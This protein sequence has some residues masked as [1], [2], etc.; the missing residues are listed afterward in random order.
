[1]AR[2]RILSK[3]GISF[4][5]TLFLVPSLAL[6]ILVY[7]WEDA[8]DLNSGITG[9]IMFADGVTFGDSI[10][11]LSDNL[12]EFSFNNSVLSDWSM[13]DF[14]YGNFLIPE[15]NGID[16]DTV[17]FAINDTNGKKAAKKSAGGS[18]TFERGDAYLDFTISGKA[19]KKAATKDGDT[20]LELFPLW[21]WFSDGPIPC[22]TG[23][24]CKKSATGYS[25]EGYWVLRS[26]TVSV[27]EPTTFLLLLT[28]L[29]VMVS[30][31][32]RVRV[33]H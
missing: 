11:P 28:G 30:V 26:G 23:K 1:M 8:N 15:A 32:K 31:I 22:E 16:L 17:N 21:S 14:V 2:I 25:G 4:L 18:Y 20:P 13:S 10:N 24:V 7:E 9:T 33:R 6:A 12:L 29:G 27:P 19:K 3:A 5:L